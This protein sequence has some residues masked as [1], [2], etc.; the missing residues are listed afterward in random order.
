[1]NKEF[2]RHPTIRNF[3]ASHDGVIRHCRLKKPIGADDNAELS[4]M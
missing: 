3:E 4:E 1:M 2:V